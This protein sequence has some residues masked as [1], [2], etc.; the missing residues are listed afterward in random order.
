MRVF[1]SVLICFAVMTTLLAEPNAWSQ[2]LY[3]TSESY[4]HLVEV[5]MSTGVVTILFTTIFHPDSLIVDSLGRILYTTGGSN[6]TISIFDPSTGTNSVIVSG[7][8]YPRDL[9]FDP[10]QTSVLVSNFGHGEID[11]VSLSTGTRVA[12]TKG[13]KT[14][15]GLAYDPEG[16]L[17]AV[18]N[19][20]TQ[21]AQIDPNT[22]VILKRLTVTTP[23]IHYYG[24]DGLT[25]DSYTGQ[26]WATDVGTGANCLVE[27][28]TDLS[29]FTLF[30]VGNFVTPDGIISDGLG[31]LY[32]GV[33]LSHVYEYNITG[34]KITKNVRVQ[35]VDDVA[36]VP[37]N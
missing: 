19:Q 3:A 12:L 26:L 21:V 36:L 25:Y 31:N 14:V 8:A 5:N 15:D 1:R 10:G 27:I 20:H 4:N 37:S 29:G 17:F 32:V 13:L 30:Q 33:N 11:R 28:P 7:L 9:I 16:R 34:N 23:L 6:G 22:G 24:L 35:S 2:N 18:I